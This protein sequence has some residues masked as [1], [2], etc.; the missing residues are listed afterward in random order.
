[1]RPMK[2]LCIH[3]TFPG[4]FKHLIPALL[5]RGDLIWAIRKP[6]P[7]DRSYVKHLKI[8]PYQLERGNGTDVHPLALE[9]ESKVLRGEAVAKV[10]NDL[11]SQGL[12][13]DLI[14]G[15][16]GWGDLLFLADVWPDV[17]QLHYLEFFHGVPGT[18]HD[19]DDSL[20][21]E[22]T[23]Q[24]RQ[25]TRMKNANLLLNLEQMDWG[26]TPTRFQHSVLPSWAQTRCSV[27]H[28]GI[29][30]NWLKP[31]HQAQL[32]LQDGRLLTYGDPV[33]TFINR[34]FEPYRGVHVFLESLALLQQRNPLAQ[35]VLVGA[36]TPNVSYGAQRNDGVGWLSALKI[37]L[38]DRLDWSRI[39]CLGTVP[40]S[41]LRHVYQISA[42]HVYLTYPFVLSWSLIEAMSCGCLVVGSDTAPVKE[43]LVDQVNGFLVPFQDPTILADRLQLALTQ[44]RQMQALR[45][46]ARKT[47]LKYNVKISIDRQLDLVD[48][49]RHIRST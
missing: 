35:A 44:P 27:I 46:G 38:G 42:A 16:P 3:P 28:D 45:H 37:Q 39:H 23:L 34:T 24:E 1:M 7:I 17:P 31:D 33:V 18:D 32:R 48:F 40:H 13:P 10:A 41:T 36:D 14:I 2:L 30:I 47:A 15:H 9:T 21:M 11:R 49:V 4:Q 8:H 29:D 22:I 43:L 5:S 19:I 12:Q 20:A 6:G 25:R 26:W